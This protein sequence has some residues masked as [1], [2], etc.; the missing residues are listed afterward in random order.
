MLERNYL[1]VVQHA[2]PEKLAKI[3]T[4]S[5]EALVRMASI[6]KKYTSGPLEGRG[7]TKSESGS[8]KD[9]EL[10][11]HT[12]VVFIAGEWGTLGV[13][14]L[15]MVYVV[16][17]IVGWW[18]LPWQPWYRGA[19]GR[20]SVSTDRISAFAGLIGLTFAGSS[21][22]MILTSYHLLPFTGKNLYLFGLDSGGDII[23]SVLLLVILAFGAAI[24]RDEQYAK[25]K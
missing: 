9:T 24:L 7:Y 13:I 5:S 18:L 6:M 3:G 10:R 19:L 8:I 20:T 25:N 14:G 1:R 21:I 11:E 22:Y 2:S 4:E 16:I 23:E 12:L 15:F 17:A